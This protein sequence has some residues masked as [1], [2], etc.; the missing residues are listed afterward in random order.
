MTEENNFADAS[1]KFR[2]ITASQYDVDRAVFPSLSDSSRGN[3]LARVSCFT[4]TVR[5]V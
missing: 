2:R 5:G 3:T 4:E 1:I